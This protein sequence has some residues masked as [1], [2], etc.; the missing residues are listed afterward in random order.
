MVST[1]DEA[2]KYTLQRLSISYLY[3]KY[4]GYVPTRIFFVF[5]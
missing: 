4:V 2:R 3:L 1:Y 5:T